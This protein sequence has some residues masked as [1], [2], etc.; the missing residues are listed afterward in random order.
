MDAYNQAQRWDEERQHRP[1]RWL[2]GCRAK[3]NLKGVIQLIGLAI[4]LQRVKLVIET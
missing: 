1:N 2:R 4:R 3:D